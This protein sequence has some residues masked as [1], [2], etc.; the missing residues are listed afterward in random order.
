MDNYEQKY[1]DALERAK[2]LQETCDSQ[3]VVG[4]CEYLFPELK[5]SKG[6]RIKWEILEYI[7]SYANLKDEKIPTEWIEWLEKQGEKNI[8][9]TDIK[10]KAHQ[11]AWETSKDY[12]PS[13]SKESWCEMAA[14]DM[15]SW[16][17]KQGKE[18]YA[19]KSFRDKD[20]HKFMQYIENEAKA[21]E[22]NLPNRSYDIYAFA[23]D[24]LYWLEKQGEQKPVD[25]VEPKFHEGDIVQYITDST[26]RRKIEEI[27]TLC[28]MYHTDSSPIMFEIEDEWKVV[29]N[30]ED[31]EQESVDKVEPKFKGGDWIVFNGLILHIDEVVNGYYRTT[32]IGYGIHNSYDWDIDNIARLWSIADAKE[33]DV[34]C[35]E[36]KNDFRIF[37]YKNGHIDYHCCYSNGHLTPIDS[38]FV[39]PEHLLCYIHPATKEQRDLLFAKMKVEGYEWDVEKMILY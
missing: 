9:H 15:A 7:N 18:E 38:F 35:Y 3:A 39:V 19:L 10:E 6:D 8:N 16:L 36:N 37:I 11:I 14:L 34:L 31:V 13:L 22:F 21:Y 17:E 25:K 20:V 29:V 4:W 24:I 5:E 27:D 12:D 23:K 33:G 32:S 30:A 2:K 1:K 28:N 26:D